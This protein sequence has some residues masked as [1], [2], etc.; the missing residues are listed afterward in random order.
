MDM[1]ATDASSCLAYVRPHTKGQIA[2][3]DQDLWKT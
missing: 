2:E 1:F 3:T